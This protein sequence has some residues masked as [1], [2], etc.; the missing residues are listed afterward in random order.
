[1]KK[2]LLSSVAVATLAMA[3]STI[4][5]DSGWQLLGTGKAITDMSSFDKASIKTVWTYNKIDNAWEVYSADDAIKKLI[6]DSSTLSSLSTI[7]ENQGF[8]VNASSSD[9][10]EINSYVA[11]SKYFTK[12]LSDVKLEDVAGKTFSVKASNWENK[13][14]SY[15]VVFDDSGV[16]SVEKDDDIDSYVPSVEF[17][18]NKLMVNGT[19]FKVL[20]KDSTGV[21]FGITDLHSYRGSMTIDGRLIY[22]VNDGV[23]EFSGSLESMLPLDVFEM[24][25]S[26]W[27]TYGE[28]YNTTRHYMS[29]GS[30]ES[31]NDGVFKID[32][33]NTIVIHNK[34]DNS[35][36]NDKNET[37]VR[38]GEY[39]YSYQL[40]YD[41]DDIMMAKYEYKDSD[42]NNAIEYNF[43]DANDS[44]VYE[45]VMLNGDTDT[46]KKVFDL[47]GNKIWSE[48]Y[49]DDGKVYY[50][51][52]AYARESYVI[53]DDGKTLTTFWAD[54]VDDIADEENTDWK[55]V[56]TEDSDG[57]TIITS[58]Y[59]STSYEVYST[60]R[61]ITYSDGRSYRAKTSRKIS[62][63]H[64]TMRE[65]KEAIYERLLNKK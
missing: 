24:D 15:S 28:D 10:L 23:E 43:K 13:I 5:I 4:S 3:G 51:D 14:Y 61:L 33:N 34:Y 35:Y 9:S 7:G 48:E 60:S 30:I 55:R 63:K 11:P 50:K 41:I 47:T 18:D 45:S 20:S 21:V 17:E 16:A 54:D 58:S 38:G 39:S 31:Y 40:I 6:D 29:D 12:G 42:W 65:A 46:W 19:A 56:I 64:K 27:T 22:A 32:N 8:W 62:P 49:R 53:S 36:I 1:M 57:N 2:V 25:R 37:L 44:Y 59:G 26:G 52:N